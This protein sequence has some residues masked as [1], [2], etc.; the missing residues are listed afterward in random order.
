MMKPQKRLLA[1]LLGSVAL[2][3]V[4]S[5]ASAQNDA[6]EH[7]V[8]ELFEVAERHNATIHSLQSAI[9]EAEAG[10]ESARMAKLPD[11][12]GQASVSYL[13][14]AR[15]WNRHFGESTS[16]PMP[17]YGNNFLLQ[18]QQVLYAGGAIRS[19]INLA[20]LN[21][22][23]QRL[24]A[25][26]TRQRVRMALVAL[27][28]QLHSLHNQQKVYVRNKQLAADQI[29]LM[30]KRREQGV[31]LRN[32]VTRYELQLQQM[33]LG[34]TAVADEQSIVRHQLLTALG[35]DSADVQMLAENA[36]DEPGDFLK[37]EAWWQQ[38]AAVNHFGLKRS[39]LATDMSRTREQMAKAERRP[40]V[41]LMAED[42]LDGPITIEVPPINKNLNYWFVGVGVTYNFSSLFKSKRHIRQAALG[43]RLASDQ[44]TVAQQQVNDEVHK[45][46]VNYGTA[47]TAL[48]T[49]RKSVQ[50]AQEN[51]EVVSNRYKNGLAIVTDL[52]DAANMKLEAELALENARIQLVQCGFAL[53]FAAHA[54]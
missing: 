15:L 30:G 31:A 20:R 16:A 9:A 51:Y 32:D 35:T 41:A 37:D 53:R 28:L 45:A 21:A 42:H 14:N 17:H 25:G 4:A 47:R 48:A 18:A 50:L 12:N 38:T 22:D 44:R 34:E 52:T 5:V 11:V 6:F 54:L 3:S 36:F 7:R 43:T 33:T 26:E 29:A 10:I 39:E 49:C 46:F 27:Y 8:N 40:K 24:A 13:G 19:Q 23:M 1:T 2:W